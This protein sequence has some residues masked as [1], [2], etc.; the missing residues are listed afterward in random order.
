MRRRSARCGV[1]DNEVN[2]MTDETMGTVL[3]NCP[4][5]GAPVAADAIACGACGFK[6]LGR[7]QA[8]KPLNMQAQ[9]SPAMANPALLSEATLKIVKGPQIG[10]SFRLAADRLTVG[11]SPQCDIFLNDMTVS[12]MHATIERTPAGFR[13]SDADSFNGLWVNNLNVKDADLR[14]GDIV[15][16]GTFCLM[17]LA[18]PTMR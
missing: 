2:A 11:R 16:I 17:Y 1:R 18:T 3:Q 10:S 6:L 4:V 12:R 9:A 13:I 15:Q 8:F 5:C 14:D 7:T